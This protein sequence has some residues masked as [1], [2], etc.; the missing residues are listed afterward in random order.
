MIRRRDWGIIHSN[1]TT[2]R[3]VLGGRKLILAP[4]AIHTNMT[5]L[6]YVRNLLWWRVGPLIVLRQRYLSLASDVAASHDEKPSL[7]RSFR[8]VLRHVSLGLPRFL[9][10]SGVHLK[11][12]PS[13][14]F[15]PLRRMWP[16]YFHRRNQ[17]SVLIFSIPASSLT[18]SL[19]IT[20]GQYIL[21]ILL[22][23]LCTKESS[24]R[25]SSSIIFQVSQP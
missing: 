9:L 24:F 1:R 19:L 6:T 22:R 17:I 14:Q 3:G 7:W 18:S 2:F 25:S 15:V 8:T 11:A 4:A 5:Y 21:R 16:R 10:P 20:I 13:L 12:T 23:H